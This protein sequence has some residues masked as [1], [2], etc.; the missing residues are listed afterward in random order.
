VNQE[1]NLKIMSFFAK[2]T[3]KINVIGNC[4]IRYAYMIFIRLLIA[5]WLRYSVGLLESPSVLRI[6]LDL[7]N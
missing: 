6:G 5:G 3:L 2:L 1:L 4:A 7:L